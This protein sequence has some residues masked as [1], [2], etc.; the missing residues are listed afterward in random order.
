MRAENE[1][2]RAEHG[3]KV[4]SLRAE[5]DGL[6]AQLSSEGSKSDED[7]AHQKPDL[8][9]LWKKYGIPKDYF[10]KVR[11]NVASVRSRTWRKV[12]RANKIEVECP[13]HAADGK[14]LD[15]ETALRLILGQVV[16]FKTGA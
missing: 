6:R 8:E 4:A 2:L 10:N 1:R 5:I 15:P 12:G 3:A 11:R 7:L 13:C 14:A 9:R 16:C